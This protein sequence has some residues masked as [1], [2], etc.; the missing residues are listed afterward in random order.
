MYYERVAGLEKIA[1]SHPEI[2][3]GFALSAARELRCLLDA[4][5]T[6]DQIMP[7]LAE[8]IAQ[9]IQD[10]LVYPGKIKVN[11]IRSVDSVE[12]A[13]KTTKK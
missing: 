9:E 2:N 6:T 13:N 1:K 5:K 12:Y 10:E 8:N 4:K 3:K 11:L 7:E